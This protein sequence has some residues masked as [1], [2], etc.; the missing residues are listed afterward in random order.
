ME[1]NNN[2]INNNTFS[3][4]K[5]IYG[6]RRSDKPEYIKIGHTELEDMNN[7]KDICQYS[8]NCDLFMEAA[9]RRIKQQTC[10]ASIKF[11]IQFASLAI[12]KNEKGKKESFTDK[13]FHKFL[14]I[15][16]I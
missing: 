5:I 13:N 16:I 11:T 4:L 1:N 10:T 6:W 15:F 9:N 2:H 3:K 8:D 7:Y 14:Q 12:K